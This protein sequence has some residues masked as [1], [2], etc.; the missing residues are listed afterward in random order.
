TLPGFV[1]LQGFEGDDGYGLGDAHHFLCF[2]VPDY[3]E[4]Y[5]IDPPVT[6]SLATIQGWGGFSYGAHTTTD[7]WLWDDD[8]V[9]ASLEFP[10]FRGLQDYNERNAYASEDTLHPWGGTPDTGSWE[11]TDW[12][13]DDDLVAGVVRWDRMLSEYLNQSR[14]DVFFLGGSDAHGSMNYNVIWDF[15]GGSLLYATTC[16]AL[17]K[18]RNAA[19]IPGDF[20][21]ANLYDALYYGRVVVTDGPFAAIGVSL[22]GTADNYESC[23]FRIG[24][25]GDIPV[26][27]LAAGLFV[28]WTSTEDW[29]DVKKIHVFLGDET[30][31][32]APV[33]AYTVAPANGMNGIEMLPLSTILDPAYAD[34]DPNPDLYIRAVAYTYDPGTGPDAPGDCS[35]PGYDAMAS[36]YQYRA[37]TNPIWLNVIENECI[38][39]GDVTLDGGITAADAQAAFYIV[40]GSMTP[41]PEQACAADCNGDDSVTAADAQLIFF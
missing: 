27:T 3:I 41:T 23:D 21:A 2:N 30:T 16:D 12:N 25:T 9:R 6:E 35:I 40:L 11:E 28:T 38:H 13:W 24:D 32:D 26:N 19:Y 1:A 4:T 33:L 37:F 18:V 22:D 5:Q 8:T 14:Y 7:G 34:G 31:G 20:N 17:G 10:C 15:L 39:D 36:D 29:G